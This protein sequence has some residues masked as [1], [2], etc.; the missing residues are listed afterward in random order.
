MHLTNKH[1]RMSLDAYEDGRNPDGVIELA[2][3]ENRLLLDFWRPRLQSCAPTT[4]T[5]R[6]GFNG[7]MTMSVI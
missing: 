5:T 3:A 1:E 6:Y 7:Q 4:A 2:Y